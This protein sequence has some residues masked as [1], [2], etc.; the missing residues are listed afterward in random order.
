M[1]STVCTLIA[2]R[3][4]MDQSCFRVHSCNVTSLQYDIVLLLLM[5]HVWWEVIYLRFCHSLAVPLSCCYN[6]AHLSGVFKT[7]NME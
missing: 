1:H 7:Q 5:G 3:Q 6:M 2:V 4:K